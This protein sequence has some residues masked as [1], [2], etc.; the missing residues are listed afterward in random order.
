MPA[1][2]L[3]PALAS[4]LGRSIFTFAFPMLLFIIVAVSLYIVFSKTTEVPGHRASSTATVAH[5]SGP[6][7]TSVA[8]TDTETLPEG[9]SAPAPGAEA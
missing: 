7:P 2:I 4:Y 6:A 1:T 5:T 8:V 9:G 3:D